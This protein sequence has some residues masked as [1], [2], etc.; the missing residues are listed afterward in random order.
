MRRH[1]VRMTDATGN[2]PAKKFPTDKKAAEPFM[3]RPARPRSRTG[4][5]Q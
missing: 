1:F 2:R 3:D 4:E 5:A